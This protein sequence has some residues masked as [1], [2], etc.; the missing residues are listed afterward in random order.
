MSD[1]RTEVVR[2]GYDRLGDRYE[3]WAAQIEDD[4]RGHF[5]G[6]LESRLDLG[7]RVLD[8]GCGAGVPTASHL[9]ERFTVLGVDF[10]HV[11][12][13]RA[14][15]QVPRATFKQADITDADFP[16]ASFDA[17]IALYSLTHVPRELHP[18]LFQR[19]AHW[20]RPGGLFV[21]SLGARG[22]EDWLGEWLGVEMFFSS[23]DADANRHL[24]RD[25]GFDLVLDEVVTM[26]EPDGPSTFHWVLSQ[27][28]LDR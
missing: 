24:L 3:A 13:E 12:L 5:V 23:W 8:L 6:E 1:H 25:A 9:A 10:S 26:Q 14:R 15:R 16:D 20:L 11:Q 19:I 21:A 7:A 17:V 18:E 4:P 2:T 28:S 27:R 22:S